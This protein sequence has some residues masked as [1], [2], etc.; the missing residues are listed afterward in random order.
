MQPP[1]SVCAVL[2]GVLVAAASTT[3]IAAAATYPTKPVRIVVGFPAAG[4]SDGI[5]RLFAKV[6][7]PELGQQVVV[8]NRAGAGTTLAADLVAKSRPDGYTLFMQDMTTHAINASLY[9]K[10]PY[11]SIK[12]FTPISLVASSPLVLVVH[13]SLPVKTVKDL[14]GLAKARPGEVNY[15]SS[16]LGTIIHLSG[17]MFKKRAGVNLVHVPYKSGTLAVLGI[18]GGEV[19]ITF[20][21]S[22]TA[23]PMAQAGKVRALAVTTAKRAAAIADVPTISEAGLP[24]FEVVLYNGVLAPANLPQEILGRLNM[25]VVKAVNAPDVK[26]YYGTISA[27]PITSTPDELAA[28]MAT[29]AVKLGIAVKESGARAD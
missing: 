18:I 12:D 11:D 9:R 20:A 4:I 22:P 3:A 8:D 15:G 26:A 23:I 29:E 2:L 5:A 7:A 1:A 19:A 10:L 21:T 27:E 16:G 6:M 25:E 17:E 14:I 28:H 13:P 24:G